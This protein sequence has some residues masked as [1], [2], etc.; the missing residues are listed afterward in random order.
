VRTVLIDLDGTLVDSAGGIMAHLAAAL[1]SQGLPVPPDDVLRRF[2]G[3]PF[4]SELPKLGLTDDE[5]AAVIVAY[6][7]SYN[8]VAATVSPPFPGARELLERLRGGGFR[9]A[10]ATSKPEHTAR[11]VVE[12][13]GLAPLLHLVAGADHV[14]GRVGKALVIASALER[15]GLDPATDDVVMVGDR[16]HDVEGAAEHGVPTLGVRWGYA[17][18]GELDGAALLVDSFDDL[19]AALLSA[20][21]WSTRTA[22]AA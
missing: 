15:L 21:V 19:R 9:L 2:V 12:A 13:H 18:P 4:E 14:A 5:T 3:P 8:A 17:E 11:D 16:H 10:L 20:G 6:R 7:R 1:A 22:P